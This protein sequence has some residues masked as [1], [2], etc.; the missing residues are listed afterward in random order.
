MAS[1]D[2]SLGTRL[3]TPPLLRP[4]AATAEREGIGA[5]IK[6]IV[7]LGGMTS[8]GIELAASR[9]IAPFFGDSTFIWANLIGLTLACLA[10]GYYLGGRV[11]DRYPFP[12]VLFTLTAVAAVAAGFVPILSR[13]ILDA[14]LRA[15]DDFAVGA[16]YGSLVGVTLLVSVPVTLLGFV[17]PYSIRLLVSDISTAGNTSGRLYALSTVGSIVGS[18][19]PVIVLIPLFGTARTFLLMALVL[20]VPSCAALFFL[21]SVRVGVVVVILAAG[22]LVATA[23]AS[24]RPIRPAERGRLVYEHESEYNYIQVVEEDGRYLLALNEGHAIHSIYDPDQLLTGGPWQYFMVAPLFEPG[25]DFQSTDSA[26]LIGLAG[27]TVA[28]QLTAAYGPIPIDGVELDPEIARVGREYFAIGEEDLPNL[29]IVVA[30]GRYFLRTTQA[31]YDLIGIDAYRQPYIP[32]QLTTKEFFG[33]VAAH[34]N[35]GGVAV[36]NVGRTETDYRLVDVIASTMNAV[37]PYVYAVDVDRYNNTIVVGSFSPNG[38]ANFAEN[39]SA[40]AL[41]SPVRV[42]AE[43]SL[44]TGNLRLIPP[45]GRVFTDDHAPVELVV[46]QIILDVAREGEDE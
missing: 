19:L 42:V 32:F 11:A 2:Q 3:D 44:A 1:T 17:T 39:A 15:F 28:R 41:G 46:D 38:L 9:L 27:G 37:F 13:P 26:L 43:A 40:L 25:A 18:F 16:F 36:V 20:F 45:G 12:R 8:I 10:L 6:L 23:A 29:N 4:A 14:S 33:E 34:L 31:R 30:D 7:F 22:L 5:L 21:G 35:A 24:D